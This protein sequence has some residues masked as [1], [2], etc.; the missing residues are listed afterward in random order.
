VR[1]V[2][3]HNNADTPSTIPPNAL[4]CRIAMRPAPTKV[5]S[6]NVTP[7][8]VDICVLSF[9]SKRVC[10][11]SRIFQNQVVEHSNEQEAVCTGSS[12]ARLGL[13]PRLRCMRTSIP[14]PSFKGRGRTGLSMVVAAMALAL[15][16][17]VASAISK[18]AKIHSSREQTR[19]TFRPAKALGLELAGA[20]GPIPA[21]PTSSPEAV[22]SMVDAL[23]RCLGRPRST[24]TTATTPR[25]T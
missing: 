6:V 15:L 9:S 16:Y 8:M 12:T 3:E 25:L 18:D 17:S 21:I 4:S 2:S 24:S 14:D 19:L 13:A 1:D 10:P 20:S 22:G 11:S 23:G 5:P 7:N